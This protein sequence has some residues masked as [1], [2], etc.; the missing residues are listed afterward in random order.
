MLEGGRAAR[1]AYVALGAPRRVSVP[2]LLA[3]FDCESLDE[4][5]AR[6]IT[7][8]LAYSGIRCRPSLFEV[9]ARRGIRAET[10]AGARRYNAPRIVAGRAGLDGEQVLLSATPAFAAQSAV[11]CGLVVAS[12]GYYRWWPYGLVALIS[13]GAALGGLIYTFPAVSDLLPGNLPRGR[14]MGGTV[15]AIVAVLAILVFAAFR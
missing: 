15:T 11:V 1:D 5:S 8:S 3:A 7:G 10:R 6:R 12:I 4:S 14:V 9:L 13:T 2:E